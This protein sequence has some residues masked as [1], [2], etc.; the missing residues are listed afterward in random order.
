MLEKGL[1]AG[2]GDAGAEGPGE[3]GV[4][5]NVNEGALLASPFCDGLAGDAP[6]LKDV[7]EGVDAPKLKLEACGG[8]KVGALDGCDWPKENVLLF[9]GAFGGKLCDV[10]MFPKGLLCG[11]AVVWPKLKLAAAGGAGA[12]CA[13]GLLSAP[14]KGL[15]KPGE[16]LA[17]DGEA[18]LDAPGRPLRGLMLDKQRVSHWLVTVSLVA[19]SLTCALPTEQLWPCA[20][21]PLLHRGNPPYRRIFLSHLVRLLRVLTWLCSAWDGDVSTPCPNQLNKSRPVRVAVAGRK[22][23]IGVSDGHVPSCV[24]L[25]V[26]I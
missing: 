14:P 26:A 18:D 21:G 2:A 16:G 5:P 4:E 7:P 12:L 1:K 9:V 6:K 22:S 8:A 13:K 24:S 17:L 25:C 19:A 20:G 10:D 23:R 11:W 15:G 3:A